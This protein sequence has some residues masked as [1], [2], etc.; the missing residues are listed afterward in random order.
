[1]GPLAPRRPDIQ[2]GGARS[3]MA[4]PSTQSGEWRSHNAPWECQRRLESAF[5]DTSF[6]SKCHWVC[7][8]ARDANPQTAERKRKL[9]AEARF[10]SRGHGS[11]RGEVRFVRAALRIWRRGD[12]VTC[13]VVCGGR[14]WRR[15]RG[16]R[17]LRQLRNCRGHQSSG[18]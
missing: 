6:A 18:E 17:R 15:G 7:K 5:I 1:M 13:D 4:A 8:T 11:R 3:K 10:S 2:D 16:W 12:F 9:R 14:S